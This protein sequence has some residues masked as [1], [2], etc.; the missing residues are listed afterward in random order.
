MKKQTIKR[1]WISNQRGMGDPIDVDSLKEV[2]STILKEL[3]DILQEDGC[4]LG[5]WEITNDTKRTTTLSDGQWL[6]KNN[7]LVYN[8]SYRESEE[9]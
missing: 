6:I 2:K 7:K 3:Y 1:Y 9:W 8:E 4:V 5:G